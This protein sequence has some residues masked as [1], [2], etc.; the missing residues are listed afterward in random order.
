MIR[1]F[2]HTRSVSGLLFAMVF[3]A[4]TARAQQPGP[5]QA[6]YLAGTTGSFVS[7][8]TFTGFPTTAF[9]IECWVKTTNQLKNGTPFAYA[10]PGGGL[11]AN[12]A[13][14]F[15]TLD[16][17]GIVFNTFSASGSVSVADGQ[18]HHVAITWTNSGE[19]R[20]YR[21]GALA[22]SNSALQTG[23]VLAPTGIV[24]L[25]QDQDSYGGSFDAAQ[26]L[27]GQL[28][29]VRLWSLALPV[30]TIQSNRSRSLP[31]ATPGL[32]AYY[33]FDETSGLVATNSTTPGNH[34]LF[35]GT[36]VVRVASTAPV[37]LPPAVTAVA[38][39]IW[40]TAVTLQGTVVPQLLGATWWMEW[41][42]S[43]QALTIGTSSVLSAGVSA[44]A[45]SNR[46]TGLPPGTSIWYRLVASNAAGTVSTPFAS[47]A[48]PT[49]WVVA[50]LA[51]DGPGSLRDAV[52]VAPTA[53]V[54]AVTASGSIA[55]GGHAIALTRS[56][57]LR[58][59]G[60]TN[61][62][63]HGNGDRLFTIASG[64]SVNLEGLK[65][66]DGLLLF[67]PAFGDAYMSGGAIFS[68]GALALTNCVLEGN[69]A[70]E[71][72]VGMYAVAGGNGGAIFA[73]GPLTLTRCAFLNNLAGNGGSPMSESAGGNGGSGGAV[74]ALQTVRVES[75]FFAGNQAGNGGYGMGGAIAYPGGFGGAGGAIS[76]GGALYAANSTWVNSRAGNGG[77][78]GAGA[79]SENGYDG[80]GGSGGALLL[81]SGGTLVNCTLTANHTGDSGPNAPLGNPPPSGGGVQMAGGSLQLLNTIVAG[82]SIQSGGN[83]ID[84]AGGIASLGH[85]LLGSAT[86]ASGLTNGVIGDLAGSATNL[87]DAALTGPVYAADPTRSHMALA[88]SSPAIN[89]GDN[90]VESPPYLL[91]VDERG[92]PR[93]NGSKVDIGSYELDLTGLSAPAV[94]VQQATLA[95]NHAMG[96]ADV[97]LGGQVQPGGLIAQLYIEYGF[98]IAYGQRSASVIQAGTNVVS[99][100]N[101]VQGLIGGHTYHYRVV[102]SNAVGQTFGPDQTYTPPTAVQPGDLNNDGVIAQAELDVL[103]TNYWDHSPWVAFTN[104]AGL[105]STNVSFALPNP[106]AW[107]FPVEVSTNLTTWTPVGSAAPYYRFTDPAATSGVPRYYRLTAP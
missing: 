89:G 83:G 86:G 37:G 88:L 68:Q 66:M 40:P 45:V 64:I 54:I 102:A 71:G 7:V 94:L 97:L 107:V 96:A 95:T 13:V 31:N 65:L 8:N 85:N 44:L 59:P 15:N 26:A 62:V 82:N 34:G 52:A 38:T 51:D 90:A 22:I 18:W 23:T 60:P 9:T 30:A 35:S 4:C 73:E 36:S 19:F 10:T 56:V 67:P 70:A 39:G 55:L 75:C 25:G 87:L 76:A 105:G 5:G 12:A 1:F 50:L 24:V 17:R 2:W 74:F 58:G 16:L 41:G 63:L 42:V 57:S 46:I 49:N 69:Q 33:R 47:F 84:V 32:V 6:L 3:S 21:D 80:V 92:A 14:L 101:L 61:L 53:T 99:F 43:T 103:L 104:V 100:T 27:E 79:F 72:F 93:R 106:G 29:E 78:G 28:D 11:E 81:G 20:L 77:M 91:T 48:T 98:T